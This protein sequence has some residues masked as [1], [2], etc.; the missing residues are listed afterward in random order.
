MRVLFVAPYIPNAL[1]TR[2]YHLLKTLASQHHITVL[3]PTFSR[4]EALDGP[5]LMADLPGLE[6]IGVA[7]QKPQAIARSLLALPRRLPMQAQFCYSPELI[8]MARQLV[9]RTRF[10]VAH[11]EHLR[12]GYI[13]KELAELGLPVVF[14]SVDCISLLVER[15]LKHG[16]LKNR[17]VSKLELSATKR[18]EGWLIRE[19]GYRASCATSQEDASALEELARVEV[20][21]VRVI[22]NGV[23]VN[24]FSPPLTKNSRLPD[25]VVFSGKMSYHAN[26]AAARYL[27]KYIW[28]KV[29]LA[30]PNARLFIVGSRPPKDL[31]ALS[32]KHGVE[33]T[34]YVADLRSYLRQAEVAVAPM[35]YGVGIQNKVLEAMACATPVVA[36]GD[37]SRAI[38]AR[39]GQELYLVP[40]GQP[41]AFADRVIEL[42]QNPKLATEMG[43][44]GRAAV[45][46]HYTWTEASQRLEQLWL[47][48]SSRQPAT[49]G[50]SLEVSLVAES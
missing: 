49:P 40:P 12:T 6:V 19:A 24:H 35:V 37:V 15:T 23:D 2:P 30:R 20:G 43:E 33:V 38:N 28:P 4:E 1:R 10:D 47:D 46:R 36:T 41:A 21:R 3:A 44:Q 45:L 25:T 8:A 27:V 14:D 48:V 5:R 11:V 32:G 29:R 26:V 18:Y 22:A 7:C 50:Y 17:L 39:D 9:R 31:L 42:L 34:G 16:P 13:G